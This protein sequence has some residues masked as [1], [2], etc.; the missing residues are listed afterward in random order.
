MK[1]ILYISNEDRAVGGSSLSLLAMLQALKG[2]VDP[3]ILFREDGPAAEHFRSEGYECVVIPFNRAT[4]HATGLK[5]L[6][7]FLPHMI[8]D[9]V[10]Q[11]RCVR[12]AS[13]LFKGIYAV[14]SNSGTVD[15]GL[16]IARRL[17][18]PHIWHIREYM[19]LGLHNRPFLGWNHWKREI[20]AS[21]C[22]I[23]ISQGL[24][25]HLSLQAH[26]NATCLPDA[27]CAA[28]DAVL[29]K[30]KDPYVVFISG[31]VSEIK[32]P[33]DAIRI[34]A[35]AKPEN[36]HL[37]IVG[38]IENGMRARLE[39]LAEHL[40]VKESI[41]FIPFVQDIKPLLSKA[42][43]ALVCTEYEGMGRVAVEAMFY[44]CP[45]IARNSG[46]SK[47]ILAEGQYGLLY[48]NIDEAAAKLSDTL[49]N[50]PLQMV[51]QAQEYAVECFSIDNYRDKIKKIY[52]SL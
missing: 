11:L 5:R 24:F 14:H 52:A 29:I 6:I 30:E 50:F 10:V 33:D 31:I 19:D 47:D 25:N 40:G 45:V 22:V 18:V 12:R 38:L 13:R 46:G 48:N 1:K 27:V 28:S 34:L 42:S 51:E 20:E 41:E 21:D 16:K 2:D 15:I 37:K 43:A 17:A 4:F 35:A 26:K 36:Y 44:G 32:R 49:R 39:A 7:R 3:V 23:A 9:A 8:A